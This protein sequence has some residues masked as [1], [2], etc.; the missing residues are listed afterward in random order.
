[1][2][3]TLQIQR[4]QAAADSLI[5][6]GVSAY[7]IPLAIAQLAHETAGFTSRVSEA[8]NNLSG[9]KYINKP[10]QVNA[11]K[12]LLSP[13]GNYYAKYDSI[14]DWAVDYVR[15]LSRG[16]RP[17]DAANITDLSNRLKQNGYYNDT[18]TNYTAGLLSWQGKFED[19]ITIKKK[20]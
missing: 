8:N 14:K 10:Y 5:D 20:V 6:A 15:I 7:F 4:A 3:Q 16:A 1:M 13:E 17:I 2:L 11:S 9:I 19:L 12:G 18:V